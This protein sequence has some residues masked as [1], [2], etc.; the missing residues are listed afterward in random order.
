MTDGRVRGSNASLAPPGGLRSGTVSAQTSTGSLYLR[1]SV[2]SVASSCGTDAS[3]WRQGP[4]GT[5]ALL[6][7]P[8]S[9]TCSAFFDFGNSMD[10]TVDGPRLSQMSAMSACLDD[11]TSPLVPEDEYGRTTSD[12]QVN[13]SPRQLQLEASEPVTSAV[14]PEPEDLATAMQ[15]AFVLGSHNPS[16]T[17]G[18]GAPPMRLGG[19]ALFARRSMGVALTTRPSG[20]Q[21]QPPQPPGVVDQADEDEAA[22]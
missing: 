17:I 3:E 6:T 9:L 13:Q 22:T 2:I 21:L 1:P 19:S 15:S 7:S 11:P 10:T 16:P 8:M 18:N 14:L 12:L 20:C 5:D 4:R